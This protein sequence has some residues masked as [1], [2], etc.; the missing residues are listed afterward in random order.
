MCTLSAEE[1]SL[2]KT[3]AR[4]SENAETEG[5]KKESVKQIKRSALNYLARR[6]HSRLELYQKLV[7]KGFQSNDIKSVLEYLQ[8]KSYQSDERFADMYIRSRINAGDGPFKI[9]IS[10]RAKGICDSLALAVFDK[11]NVDWFEHA[12][13]L[14][15]KR[16]GESL[17]EDLTAL[18][19]QVRYL[20][21]K[22]FYQDHVNAVIHCSNHP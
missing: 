18:A 6:D 21:S 10:L 3:D 8:S 4:R 17:P 13:A 14:K 12:K 2:Q 11:L 20:K 5:V 7:A 22:G 9:K 1:Y 19:K 15:N 16:F